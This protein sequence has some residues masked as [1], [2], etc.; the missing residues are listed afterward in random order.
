MFNNKKFIF[1]FTFV[2]AWIFYYIFEACMLT[3]DYVLIDMG[4]PST[5]GLMFGPVG[6]LGQASATFFASVLDGND[7]TGSFIDSVI[8]FY[9]SLLTYKLWYTSFKKYGV[10]TPRFDSSYNIIK[11]VVLRIVMGIVYW[12]LISLTFEAYPNFSVIYPLSSNV[13]RISYILNDFTFSVV[14]GLIFVSIFNYFRIPFQY[15]EKWNSK[16]I[17]IPS[18]Y[19]AVAT[20]FIIFYLIFAMN[21][22]YINNNFLDNVVFLVMVI[23]SFLYL[24]NYSEIKVKVENHKFSIIE[25]I[26]L[27]FVLVLILLTGSN[28][29]IFRAFIVANYNL[30]SDYAWLVATSFSTLFVIIFLVLHIRI[31][32]NILTNPIYDLI[33]TVNEY[34]T[35]KNSKV[36]YSKLNKYQ[37]K[38]DD[39]GRLVRIFLDLIE[40]IKNNLINIEKTTAENERFETEFCIAGEIQEDM[41]PDDFEEFSENRPFE[42][43]G[44]MKPA[45]EVGG[46]FY[47]YFDV[48]EDTINFV[49]GDVSGKGIHATLFM[50]KTMYLIRNQSEFN[51]NLSDVV[52]KVN[53][54]DCERN[55]EDLFVTSWIGQLNLKTGKL[56]YVNAGHNPPLIRQNNGDFEYLNSSPNFV[57]GGFDGIPYEQY[58][59]DLNPGDTIFLYTD[60]ITEA[61]DHYGGFYGEDR[62]KDVLNQNKNDK[63]SEIIDK[64]NQDIAEF[65]NY[66]DPFDDSTMLIIKYEGD[67]NNE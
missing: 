25:K 4:L 34:K 24:I 32:E 54:L 29:D 38:D 62:L 28:F 55:D 21:D 17:N 1:I 65:C 14:L 56:V 33:H 44:Y 16:I 47:D 43:Y 11:F 7:I 35:T 36:T 3:G 64:I 12:A 27:I 63:L 57:I 40:R 9:I 23:V 45:Y 41:L 18:K 53:D 6:A 48:D 5:L 8:L 58:E 59:M 26:I 66:H 15:P 19:F 13:N 50:V 30:N 42:I 46:D 31:V 39:V 60:G 20:V 61:N 67:S 49:I 51:D 37:K 2:I 52:E 22:T 10:S